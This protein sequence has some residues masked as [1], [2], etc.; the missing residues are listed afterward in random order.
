MYFKQTNN[1]DDDD[2]AS[3]SGSTFQM[4]NYTTAKNKTKIG[5]IKYSAIKAKIFSFPSYSISPSFNFK[6][7]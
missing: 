2:D 4:L 6:S 3:N 1:D 5:I 7:C